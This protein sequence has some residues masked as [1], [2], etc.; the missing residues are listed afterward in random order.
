M[1]EQILSLKVGASLSENEFTLDELLLASKELFEREGI[2]GF[3]QVLLRLLDD[4]VYKK[5]LGVGRHDCCKK[6]HLVVTRR[7]EK[8]TVRTGVGTVTVLW[9]RLKC[10]SCHK[11]TIPLRTFLGLDRYQ[12][13]SVE[14]EKT[15]VELLSEQSYRRGEVH[16]KSIGSIEI[17]HTT[18]H[19]WVMASC[20]D[21]IPL[22]GRCD[23]LVADGTGYKKKAEYESN[24]GEVKVVVGVDRDGGVRPYGAWTDESWQSIGQMIKAANHPNERVKFK[25]IANVL[26]SDGEAGLIH[27]L[28][29]LTLD[30]QRCHWHIVKDIYQPLRIEGGA[31]IEETRSFQGELA[32][33]IELH[34][35]EEDFDQVSAEEKLGLEK[36]IWMAEKGVQDL[37]DELITKGYGDAARYLIRAKKGMFAYLRT[38]LHMGLKNPRVSSMIERM[39]REIG[40]R[41]KKIGFGW[42]KKGAEKMTKIIIKRITSAGEWE[43]YWKNRLNI[44]GNV[45]LTF[46]G[47]EIMEPS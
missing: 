11:T 33:A 22:K 23:T 2:P 26:V 43:E 19:R 7:E 12:K 27:G 16:L 41:I 20:C 42:S 46:L 38:W 14:L 34:I 39:M 15:V 4:M 44:T 40:R 9:T 32:A 6:S 29:K 28:K 8:K 10:K 35:P 13:K 25:A 5:V 47:C 30:H 17:P 37:I 36:K 21:E 3:L 45:R 18:L 24:R 1:I 31:S